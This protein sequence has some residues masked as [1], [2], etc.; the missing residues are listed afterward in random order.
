MI[1]YTEGKDKEALDYVNKALRYNGGNVQA[2]ALGGDILRRNG[3]YSKAIEPYEKVVRAK[4]ADERVLL[5]LA[6]CYCRVNNYK[7]LE[8]VSSL[9]HEQ[10][11]DKEALQKIELRALIQQKRMEDAEKLLKQMNGVKEDSEF[12]LLRALC[13]LAAG[14]RAT[15]TE[16]AQKAVELDPKNREAIELQRFLS[17]EM[18]IRK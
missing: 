9:L 4:R 6:E 14:R 16:M 15:A 2:L 10:G 12:V 18:E 13:E 3:S 5:S 7:L 1:Y 11:R 17:K 8:Q